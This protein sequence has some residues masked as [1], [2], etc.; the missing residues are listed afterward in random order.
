MRYLRQNYTP[1]VRPNCDV[2]TKHPILFSCITP[3][4]RNLAIANRL[5]VC[6]THKVTTVNFQQYSPNDF[7]SSLLTFELMVVGRKT[8]AC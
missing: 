2:F 8:S 7:Q 3:R 5:R 4:T 6:C 1:I